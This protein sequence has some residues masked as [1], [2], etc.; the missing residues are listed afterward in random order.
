[1]RLRLLQHCFRLP[2]ICTPIIVQ[3]TCVQYMSSSTYLHHFSDGG[4]FSSAAKIGTNP[5]QWSLL[6]YCIGLLWAWNG[7]LGSANILCAH[8][9]ARSLTRKE[10]ISSPS[11]HILSSLY[12]PE[13]AHDSYG[14]V[15]LSSEFRG[16]R[17]GPEIGAF[18]VILGLCYL[19]LHANDNQRITQSTPRAMDVVITVG[20]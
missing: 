7:K 18:Y 6:I 20:N 19:S 14:E 8:S 17:F 1:M 11:W 2:H 15:F 10:L 3:C 13:C 5:C 4:K 12:I 16:Q 9:P